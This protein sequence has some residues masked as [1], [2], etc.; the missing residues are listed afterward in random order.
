[1][2]IILLRV[3]DV[4]LSRTFKESLS[5]IIPAIYSVL[6]WFQLI[7]TVELNCILLGFYPSRRVE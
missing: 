5:H 7:G 1:V 4:K 6:P 2:K 3:F